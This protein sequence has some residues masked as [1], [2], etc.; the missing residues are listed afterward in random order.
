[1]SEKSR[2]YA[3]SQSCIKITVNSKA[4]PK[5]N[6]DISI[7]AYKDARTECKGRGLRENTVDI[8]E[9]IY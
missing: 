3:T 2:I 8:K 9:R 4:I 1:M 7:L 6:D 5:S